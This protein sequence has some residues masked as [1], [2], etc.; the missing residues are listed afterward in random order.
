MI[1]EQVG[2]VQR[3][4]SHSNRGIFE[5]CPEALLALPQGL[6]DAPTLGGVFQEDDDA[7]GLPARV[8]PGVYL[9]AYVVLLTVGGGPFL[10][11]FERFAG[12]AALMQRLPMLWHVG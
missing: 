1:D 4:L 5:D 12:Q 11:V 2:A 6:I 10:F 9:P 3:Q 7:A 8:A